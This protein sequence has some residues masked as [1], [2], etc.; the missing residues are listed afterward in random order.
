MCTQR[1][2]LIG[3]TTS[4]VEAK[5]VRCPL[6]TP[7]RTSRHVRFFRRLWGLGFRNLSGDSFVRLALISRSA[8]RRRIAVS[9]SNLLAVNV[10][11]LPSALRKNDVSAIKH[12]ERRSNPN[13][14][15]VSGV[16]LS[17]GLRQGARRSDIVQ[18]SPQYRHI[19]DRY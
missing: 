1:T 10:V 7:T 8:Q 12:D 9:R 4:V 17:E 3:W 18:C 16:S 14:S 13:Q 19:E 5:A 15:S 11:A 2:W 6:L